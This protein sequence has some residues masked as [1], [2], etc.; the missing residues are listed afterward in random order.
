[1]QTAGTHCANDENNKKVAD[2]SEQYIYLAFHRITME[3]ML[4]IHPR[5]VMQDLRFMLG[6]VTISVLRPLMGNA[7]WINLS[8][9]ELGIGLPEM[10]RI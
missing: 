5:Q 9:F 7:T 6:G 10:P 1:M 3:I 8:A 4:L 2:I